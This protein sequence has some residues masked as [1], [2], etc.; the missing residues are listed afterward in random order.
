[1]RCGEVVGAHLVGRGRP[2]SGLPQLD[3]IERSDDHDLSLQAA[4]VAQAGRDD[5][6]SLR[7][8]LNLECAGKEEARE[9]AG[10]S[11]GIALLADSLG[12]PLPCLVR[13]DRE[14]AVHPARDM[15]PGRE[16]GPE[17]RR[18][19]HPPLGVDR[20]PELAGEHTATSGS[21][22]NEWTRSPPGIAFASPDWR[23]STLSPHLAPLWTTSRHLT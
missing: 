21:A 7:V 17:A 6:A 10:S 9:G 4:E 1:M 18:H 22:A 2:A 13:E 16:L 15:C 19:C 14:T 23:S 11:V 8:E 20:V 12:Q 5:D 3:V